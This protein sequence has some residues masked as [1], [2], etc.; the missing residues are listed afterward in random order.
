MEY[1]DGVIN[2][3]DIDDIFIEHFGVKGMKWGVRKAIDNVS[4]KIR[5]KK[6]MKNVGRMMRSGFT[7]DTAKFHRRLMKGAGFSGK[8]NYTQRMKVK[9]SFKLDRIDDFKAFPKT[10]LSKIS[11]ISKKAIQSFGSSKVKTFRNDRIKNLN[12]AY[13]QHNKEIK[14]RRKPSFYSYMKGAAKTWKNPRV[15]DWDF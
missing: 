15:M 6:T 10:T 4:N 1:Y 12:K 13:K 5:N 3:P 9:E 11:K 8:L 7:K 2:K 14:N